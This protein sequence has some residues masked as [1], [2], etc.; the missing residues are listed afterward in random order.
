M[1]DGK[2][3]GD[4]Q[5]PHLNGL[6][7]LASTWIVCG[8]FIPREDSMF[9]NRGVQR[10]AVPV[11]FFILLSGFVTHWAHGHKNISSWEEVRRFYVRRVGRVV[12]STFV[13]MLVGLVLESMVKG[14]FLAFSKTARCF[15]FID[16]WLYPPNPKESDSWCPNGQTWTV[17]ALLPAWIL[18]PLVTRVVRVVQESFGFS[19]LVLMAC[20]LWIVSFG[21]SVLIIMRHGRMTL[22]DNS[23]TYYWPPSQLAD[24]FIGV[25]FAAMARHTA[26]A[27][28]TQ[29]KTVTRLQ[30]S[31]ASL[32]GWLADFMVVIVL[33]LS[34]GLNYSDYKEGTEPLYNHGLVPFL[35]WFLYLSVDGGGSG[36]M[37]RLAS[38]R[39][40]VKLGGYSFMVFLFQSPVHI[41]FA[42][43]EPR[44][45]D[46]CEGFMAFFI[47]LWFVAG[48]YAEQ[49]EA[50]IVRWLR[51]T[52]AESGD[53]NNKQDVRERA[54]K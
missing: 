13:A 8:H 18:Y 24:F 36:C 31:V 20:F 14:K 7:V 38:H 27:P 9:L 54:A 53:T 32:K 26:S 25:V 17:A 45:S 34:A 16:V 11:C 22:T 6:R 19:A 5:L 48:V 44:L 3:G 4:E 21:P 49:V 46:S 28:R 43:L 29:N 15:C 10:G 2:R 12:V 47:T 33:V 52:T 1:G 41:V 35:A 42:L 30:I 51:E 39:A 40:I 23:F 50:P 37:A